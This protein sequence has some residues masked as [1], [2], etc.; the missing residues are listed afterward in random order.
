[1]MENCREVCR[2]LFSERTQYYHRWYHEKPLVIGTRRREELARM[3]E[4]MYKCVVF[5]AGHWQEYVQDYMPLGEKETA[6]LEYQSRRPFKAGAYR[7]DYLVSRDGRLLLVEITSRF[8]AHGIWMSFYAEAAAE[9]FAARFPSEERICLYDE[10]WEY[11]RLLVP[12]GRR[13]V[14]LKS[15]DKTNEIALYKAFYE[16]FGHEVTVLEADEVESRR[17]LWEKNAF[18]ISALNQTD[19][20]SFSM[21]TLRAMVDAGM[22][23]D[24]RTILLIHDKRFFHLWFEDSFTDRCLSR[25]ETEFLRSHTIPTHLYGSDAQVWDDAYANKDRYILKHHSLGKSV[26]VYAGCMTSEEE[27][28]SLFESGTVKDMIL[29][30]FIDQRTFHTVWE[31]TPFDDYI[32]GMMLC[33]DDRY[34]GSGTVRTSSAPVTNKTDD[35]KMCIIESDSE[36]FAQNGNVL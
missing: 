19:L 22:V 21:D 4:I 24:L 1:M 14:V 25:E 34:F 31:G 23:N 26:S 7:P 18:V 16:H 10:M 9:K 11:M 17:A 8:F 13:I 12:E 36:I 15:A 29:Q 20:M 27:W 2:Q 6:I 5:M 3:H 32:C 30:P 35:R 28:R 33:V